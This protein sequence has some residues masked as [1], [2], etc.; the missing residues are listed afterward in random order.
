MFKLATDEAP[1]VVQEPAEAHVPQ[2]PVADAPAE[3]L[4]QQ[5]P[6][7]EAPAVKPPLNVVN[8]NLDAVPTAEENPTK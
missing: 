4:P 1:V 6:S 7:A 5:P 8:A 2:I 3:I